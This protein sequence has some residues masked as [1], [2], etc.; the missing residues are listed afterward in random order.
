MTPHTD[1]TPAQLLRAAATYLDT[2]G[3]HQG[4]RYEFTG[5]LMPTPAACAVGALCIAAYGNV[6]ADLICQPEPTPAQWQ[7]LIGVFRVF[8]DY[9][10]GV[11]QTHPVCPEDVDDDVYESIIGGWNDHPDRTATQVTTTL[12]TAADEWDRLHPGGGAT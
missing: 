4:S 7:A 2:H 10:T 8:T 5:E 9:L 11:Q 1:P 3:W 6:M 12:R